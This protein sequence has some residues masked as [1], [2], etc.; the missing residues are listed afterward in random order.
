[1]AIPAESGGAPSIRAKALRSPARPLTATHMASPL[2]CASARA[3]ASTRWAAS[4]LIVACSMVSLTGASSRSR[5]SAG[6]QHPAHS[7]TMT[8]SPARDKERVPQSGS[9][10]MCLSVVPLSGTAC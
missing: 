9:G 4:T 10:T 7:R 2:L 6:T 1:M 3:A 8:G 5:R